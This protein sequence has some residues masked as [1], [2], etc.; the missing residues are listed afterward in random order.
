LSPWIVIHSDVIVKTLE[1][2]EE[3]LKRVS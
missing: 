2:L 3:A 1:A